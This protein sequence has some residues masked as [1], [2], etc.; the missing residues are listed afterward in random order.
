MNFFTAERRIVSLYFLSISREMISHD[1]E[2]TW[3]VQSGKFP[4][5][6]SRFR[7]KIR[8][9]FPTVLDPFTNNSPFSGRVFSPSH[10][11][12]VFSRK[13]AFREITFSPQ[14]RWQEMFQLKQI[15]FQ[16]FKR[17]VAHR[18]MQ[19]GCCANTLFL[20]SARKA[21]YLFT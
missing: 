14:G 6:F 21:L 20:N 3:K 8:L 2:R 13:N 1:I 9:H 11:K 4:R 19:N 16:K 18:V 10:K 15:A 5:V 12:I 7:E 17:I